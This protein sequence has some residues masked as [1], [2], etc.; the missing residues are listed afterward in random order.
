MPE[1]VSAAT[2]AAKQ[3]SLRVDGIEAWGEPARGCYATWLSVT[4]ERG[5]PDA[6]AD[7]LIANLSATPALAG[8][9]VTDV[10]KP[11]VKT[12]ETGVL[13]LAFARAAYHGRMRA[14]IGKTG[15]YAVLACFWNEREPAACEAA[16]SEL[17]GSMK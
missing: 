6:L 16:C 1:L 3:S 8:I 12:A 13:S 7:L 15:A 14:Q 11:T 10:V 4:G 2:E 9:T 5:A 17:L